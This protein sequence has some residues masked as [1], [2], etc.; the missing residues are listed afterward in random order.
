MQRRGKITLGILLQQDHAPPHQSRV[1]QADVRDLG[2][3]LVVHPPYSPDFAP[4][5]FFLFP[6]LKSQLRDRRFETRA[7]LGSA[8]YQFLKHWPED[9]FLEALRKLPERWEK[10]IRAKGEYFE[11]VDI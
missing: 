5:D 2:Y 7:A 9:A 11:S 4:S 1:A 8:I 6:K 10:C 3:S